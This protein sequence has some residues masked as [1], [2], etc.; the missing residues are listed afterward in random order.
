MA[1]PDELFVLGTPSQR[2]VVTT[3]T[4]RA[5]TEL[6]VRLVER[7]DALIRAAQGQGL[8]LRDPRVHDLRLV[9]SRS[10]SLR[11]RSTAAPRC[12]H[13]YVGDFIVS[14]QVYR[15]TLEPPEPLKEASPRRNRR[16][17]EEGHVDGC[18]PIRWCPGN[19]G[20][21]TKT[22]PIAA[23][24]SGVTARSGLGY[25]NVP[26]TVSTARR[27]RMLTCHLIPRRSGD[28]KEPRGGIRGV[29]PGKA[30]Y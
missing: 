23:N 6:Q 9:R 5:A 18:L 10:P 7:S 2:L 19:L 27:S 28:V 1:R 16:V 24:S 21:Q 25:G 11:A 3:F 26:T 4:R 8:L 13:T 30:I 14:P 29:I 12:Q 15:P 20:G 17:Q 22:G